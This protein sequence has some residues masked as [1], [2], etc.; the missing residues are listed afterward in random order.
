[1]LAKIPSI[2]RVIVSYLMTLRY[3]LRALEQSWHSG[4]LVCS[5]CHGVLDDMGSSLFVKGDL[6]LCR[7]DYIRLFGSGGQCSGCFGEIASHECVIRARDL[8]FHPECFRCFR[9]GRRLCTGDRFY[10]ENSRPICESSIID[11]SLCA[12]SQNMQC[13]LNEKTTR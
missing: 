2:T 9:C 4:C 13:L 10:L 7:H 11:P 8:V 1:M 3:I 6:V 5:V 12:A